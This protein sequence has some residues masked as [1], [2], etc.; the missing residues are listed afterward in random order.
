[1]V[2]IYCIEDINGLKYVGSTKRNMH[3][4]FRQ[5]YNHKKM[6]TS[7]CSSKKLDLLNCEIYEL[8]WCEDSNRK[9]RESYWINKL[10]C[11]NI[12][13][14]NKSPKTYYKNNRE[15]C[16]KKSKEYQKLDKQKHY[17]VEYYNKKKHDNN[18][19]NKKKEY[20]R[21]YKLLNSKRV[22]NGCYEFIQML[23]EY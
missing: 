7:T 1:M 20:N 13:K 5:H 16:L 15:L 9:E 3:V 4:R 8:E 18:F 6:N 14:L 22:V 2:L 23:N 21:E 17:R 19:I 12:L 11:V 10:D